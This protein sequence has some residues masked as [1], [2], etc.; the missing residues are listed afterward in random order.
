MLKIYVNLR[1]NFETPN[2]GYLDFDG[3]FSMWV[4]EGW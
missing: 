4:T 1:T 3:T 2:S